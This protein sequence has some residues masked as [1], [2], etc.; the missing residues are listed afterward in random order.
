V[1]RKDFHKSEPN[2]SQINILAQKYR[3]GR[4][5]THAADTPGTTYFRLFIPAMSNGSM[6]ECSQTLIASIAAYRLLRLSVDAA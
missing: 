5:P 4:G 3:G 2:P 6:A 1:R